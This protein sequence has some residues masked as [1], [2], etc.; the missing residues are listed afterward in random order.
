MYGG[1]FEVFVSIRVH[2]CFIHRRKQR[3]LSQV[4]NTFTEVGST[5]PR[6]KNMDDA[7]QLHGF[8]ASFFMA[9]SDEKAKALESAE[10]LPS[11]DNPLYFCANFIHSLATEVRIFAQEN[12]RLIVVPCLNNMH[13]RIVKTPTKCR[14]ERTFFLSLMNDLTRPL[15][16]FQK[17]RVHPWETRYSS[18]FLG[19]RS[20][21]L[22][23]EHTTWFLFGRR[24]QANP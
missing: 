24:S 12:T 17:Y 14:V 22:R 5:K 6:E 9:D 21:T 11:F 19:Q 1:D 15:I 13:A 2:C 18:Q 4:S 20:V 7:F 3:N 23:Y 8:S 10:M 16:S